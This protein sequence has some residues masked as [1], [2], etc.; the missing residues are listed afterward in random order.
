[1]FERKGNDLYVDVPIPFLMA[2]LGGEVRVPTLNGQVALKIPPETQN[3][4]VFR[5]TNKGMPVLN[6]SGFGNL[7]ARA[8]IVMPKN[9]TSREKEL[10]EQLRSLKTQ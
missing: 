5:L 4:N 1:M 3:G 2:V 10:F 6:K 7:F 9:L 8:K